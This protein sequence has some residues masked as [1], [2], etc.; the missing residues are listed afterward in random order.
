MSKITIDNFVGTRTRFQRLRDAK[1]FSGWIEAYNGSMLDLSTNSNHTMNIGEEFRVEGYGHKIS[2]VVNAKLSEIG[3][4]DLVKEGKLPSV[5]G[6]NARTIEAKRDL[7]R[8]EV[9][10]S[11]RFASSSE[12]VRIKTPAIPLLVKQGSNELQGFSLDVSQQGIAFTTSGTL[13]VNEQVDAQIQTSRGVIVCSGTVRYCL[14]DKD[15]VGMC[16]CALHLDPFDRISAPKWEAF[17]ASL[18]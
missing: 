9:L 15:R 12:N 14:P 16:R 5:E 8:M 7:F 10:G 1:I 18:D 4:L 11:V 17:M 2:M 13:V 3:K 6:T